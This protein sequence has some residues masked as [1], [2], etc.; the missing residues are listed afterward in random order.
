MSR[1]RDRGP[2]VY[3]DKPATTRDHIPPRCLFGE[4]KPSNLVTVPACEKCN[5]GAAR[6]DEYAMRLALVEG[7]QRTQAGREVDE[8]FN[9]A[10]ARPQAKGL[11]TGFMRTVHPVY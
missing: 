9:R 6:D 11:L 2:C 3:C 10:I 8:A 1:K 5:N 7:T 4:N